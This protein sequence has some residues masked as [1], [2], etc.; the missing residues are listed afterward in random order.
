MIVQSYSNHKQEFKGD[1]RSLFWW[2][3]KSEI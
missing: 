2:R 3:T 1:V